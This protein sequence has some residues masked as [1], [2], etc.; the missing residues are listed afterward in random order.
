ML[1]RLVCGL[2]VAGVGADVFEGT[3]NVLGHGGHVASGGH[4]SV[5]IGHI[6]DLDVL[7]LGRRVEVSA[8]DLLA[9][10]SVLLSLDAVLRLVGVGVAAVG[11]DVQR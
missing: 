8:L 1:R 9:A 11:V 5:L 10:E 3:A 7:T 4:E 6:G 2:N